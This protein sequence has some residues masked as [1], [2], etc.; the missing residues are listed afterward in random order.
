MHI[1]NPIRRKLAN[2]EIVMGMMHFTGSP[3]MVEIMAS[4]GLDFFIIDMEHSPIDIGLAAHLVRTA[5]ACGIT[6][7][8]RVPEVNAGLIKKL[9]N[10]GVRGIVI[11]HATRE[12]CAAAVRAVRYAPAGDRGSCPAVRQA[13]YG[14]PDWQAFTRQANDEIL[15]IPLLEEKSTIDDFEALATMSGLDVF[16]LG[17]FDFSVSAGVPGAGFDH[18][19]VA[20]ALER[21]VKLARANGKYIMTTVGDNISTEYCAEILGRGVQMVSYSADAL[22]FRRA[23]RDIAQLKSIKV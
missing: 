12:S 2:G 10:L 21:I 1:D 7:L 8:V 22:V 11:P 18:P 19:V 9:L 4:T 23:C 13:G 3:M 14:A 16:F 5:D 17:T 6:P 15:I 20:A